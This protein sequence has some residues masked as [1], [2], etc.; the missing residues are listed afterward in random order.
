MGRA[1]GP[2]SRVESTRRSLR[3]SDVE[4]VAACEASDPADRFMHAHLAAIRAAAVIV[5]L[6]GRPSPRTGARTV[7]EMLTYVSPDLAAWAVYFAA[8][9]RERAAL[10]AGKLD[11][12]DQ[13][14]ADEL[15]AC[16]E[17]FRDE[18]AMALDPDA[19]FVQYPLRAVAS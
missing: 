14:R 6:H 18:V 17:D 5:E 9:A 12:V 2:A 13:T 4:L 8:G 16:A 1:G 19:T 15:L 10:E 7:W 11:A 3:R